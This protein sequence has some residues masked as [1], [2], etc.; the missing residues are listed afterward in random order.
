MACGTFIGIA[1][2]P[3]IYDIM[4]VSVSLMAYVRRAQQDDRAPATRPWVPSAGREP[5]RRTS[6]PAGQIASPARHQ[7]IPSEWSAGRS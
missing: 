7:A 4:A 6:T 2:Q 3:F 5:G 1:F